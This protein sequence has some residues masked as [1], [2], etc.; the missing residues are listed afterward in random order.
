M[1]VYV[2]IQGCKPLRITDIKEDAELYCTKRGMDIQY[3]GVI[4]D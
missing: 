1:Y 2:C 3:T 4:G